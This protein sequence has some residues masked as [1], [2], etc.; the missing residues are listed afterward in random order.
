MNWLKSRP[1]GVVCLLGLVTNTPK[2]IRSKAK[3]NQTDNLKN[4]LKLL[5]LIVA[6]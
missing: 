6:V 4:Y 5:N 3:T 1:L 2:P